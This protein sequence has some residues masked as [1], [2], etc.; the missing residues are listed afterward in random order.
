ADLK[1]IRNAGFRSV[2]CN[3]PDSEG[4]AHPAFDEIAAAAREL[5]LEAR[6]LPVER[7]GIGDAEID[8]FGEL[9]DTLQKPVLAYCRSGSR[10]GLLWSRLSAR[11]TAEAPASV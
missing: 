3:R 1:A 8:A 2:I 5:G 7:D 6:Y 4:D 11:R 10:S 9:I